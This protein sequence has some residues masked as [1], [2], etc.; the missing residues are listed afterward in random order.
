MNFIDILICIPI[1]WGI[2]KGVTQ[3]LVTQAAGLAAFFAGVW[4]ATRFS[5]NLKVVFTFAGKYASVVSFSVLFLFAVILVFLV[6]KLISKMVD[7]ASLSSVNKMAGAVFGGLKFA[8][9]LSVFF[10]VL[11]AVERSY[12]MLSVETKKGSLLY[13]PVAKIA[14]AVIPGLGQQKLE[15]MMPRHEDV[16]INVTIENG[17]KSGNE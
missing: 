8:L 15:T 6:A 3:G 11:D 2:Y 7:G 12:P 16:K 5:E 17:K 10:F 4:V 9:I 14:P 13:G 1:I